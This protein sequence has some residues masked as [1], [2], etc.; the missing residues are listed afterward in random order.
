MPDPTPTAT[1]DPIAQLLD[2]FAE[3]LVEAQSLVGEVARHMAAGQ[4]EA[5]NAATERL[6]TLAT[7]CRLIQNHLIQ[8]PAIDSAAAAAAR[9]R[10]R[11][12]AEAL[13]RRSAIQGGVL[14]GLVELSRRILAALDETPGDYDAYGRAHCGKLPSL[15]LQELV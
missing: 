1:L 5:I 12:V 10:L 6:S 9:D 2:R 4:V 3:R 7:E 14:S 15:R 11:D 13:A 8:A